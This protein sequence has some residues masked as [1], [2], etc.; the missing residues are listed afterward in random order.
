MLNHNFHNFTHSSNL[1]DHDKWC[2]LLEGGCGGLDKRTIG[3]GAPSV[4]SLTPRRLRPSAFA[5]HC[6]PEPARSTPSKKVERK[7]ATHDVARQCW[8]A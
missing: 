6:H 3:G 2:W 4:H 5:F 1:H 8:P 7:R